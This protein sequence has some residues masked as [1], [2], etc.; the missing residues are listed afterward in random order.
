LVVA[1]LGCSVA[2]VGQ[3]LIQF[4]ILTVAGYLGR[5]QLRII[6]YPLEENRVLREQLGEPQR[7][8]RAASWLTWSLQLSTQM[9]IL[10][11]TKA[12]AAVSV[13]PTVATWGNI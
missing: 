13:A 9:D 10:V 6:E 1:G 12:L 7:V 11:S 3:H 2:A 5:E 8:A 4:V